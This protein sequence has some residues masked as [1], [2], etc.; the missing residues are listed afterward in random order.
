MN[1]VLEAIKTRRSIRSYEAKAVPL[2]ILQ[3]LVE[4]ANQAP[5]AMNT[6]PWR[7]VVVTDQ[8][9]RQLLAQTAAP[10]ARKYFDAFRESNPERYAVIMKRF[11]DM[12]DPVYYSAPA[13]I[14]VIGSGPQAAEGCPMACLNLMLA[15]RSLGLGTCWVKLGSLITE[16]PEI[17]KTLNLKEDE[18][19][20]GPIILGYPREIPE[21]PKKKEPAVIWI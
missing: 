2:D 13:V 17:T 9:L 14:F 18:Q 21:E 20:F 15:A 3:M 4:A 12:T 1:E 8:K 10:N 5:S 11:D 6:Q 7:F 19:I 16:N